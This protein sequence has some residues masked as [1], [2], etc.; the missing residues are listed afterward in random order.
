[1]RLDFKK[2]VVAVLL[3]VLS[4]QAE[5]LASPRPYV[6]PDYV[7]SHQLKQRYRVPNRVNV[8]RATLA[9]LKNL[10]GMD[11]SLALKLIRLRKSFHL[12]NLT[13]FYR[14]PLVDRR[15]IEVLVDRLRHRID[16]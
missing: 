11:E 13:D 16:F 9:E 5:A 12:T 15:E 14:L 4:F 8:N 1:M 3:L 10:P 6:H 7:F 2:V